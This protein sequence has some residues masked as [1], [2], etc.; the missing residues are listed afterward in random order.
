MTFQEE[1]EQ[2]KREG[3]SFSVSNVV[4]NSVNL[5]TKKLLW[6]SIA[7]IIIIS[8]IS[9]I[10]NFIPSLFGS[11]PQYPDMSGGTS[12]SLNDL[13]AFYDAYFTTPVLITS[14]IGSI[15]CYTLYYSYLFIARKAD[16]DEVYSMGDMFTILKSDKRWGFIGLFIIIMAFVSIGFA[17]FFLPGIYLAVAT[18]LAVPIHLF[19]DNISPMD[20]IKASISTVN[21]NFFSIL[22]AQILLGLIS[23]AGI[24][25]C[26]I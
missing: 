17:C 23:M 19:N 14:I 3:Y 24:I 2:I 5:V 13:M 18:S 22:W 11:F 7:F 20:A 12:P 6:F 8:T 15:I 21:K 25:I 1:L 26:C 4:S 10:I 9:S 16:R